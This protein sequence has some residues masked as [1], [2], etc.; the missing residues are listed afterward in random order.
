VRLGGL[1]W[2]RLL[3]LMRKE[4]RQ[5][6]RDPQALRLVLAAPIIQLIVFG[7]AVN[8][9]IRH[10][11]VILFDR[12][13]TT[14]SRELGQTL[15][16]SGHFRI[17]ANADRAQDLVEALDHGRAI[18]GVEVPRGFEGALAAGTPATVQVLV[19]GTMSNTAT[20]AQAY[21][22]QIILRFGQEH[23]TLAAQTAQLRGGGL[24]GVDLR[25][26]S[27]YNPNLESRIY[28]VPAV[29][30]SVMMLM[31]LLLTSLAVVREREVGTLEQLMVSPLKPAE[32]I[33][34]KTVPVVGIALV[35]LTLIASIAIL[36]FGIPM[37]GSFLLLLLASLVYIVCGLG[38]GLLI[39]TVSATT[40]EAFMTMFMFF[41][42]AMIFSGFFFPIANMPTVFQFVS[43]LDPIRYYLATVRGIFLKGAGITVLWPQIAALA[44]MGGTILW[45]A[46]TRF[47][48]TSV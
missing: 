34:G 18:L 38:I 5:T 40:Q 44:V 14:V 31:S 47:R 25:V 13:H 17:V 42:P 23:S 20:V 6:R 48:K 35:D 26:R 46:S 3:E 16:A 41:L 43:L 30:G 37:R 24:P 29:M 33:L 12:D 39:S 10:V 21:A 22:A 36:W 15:M 28:N 7:Y 8:T 1:D 9:D 11:A 27:W 19:D 32:L 45:F 2:G 4:L